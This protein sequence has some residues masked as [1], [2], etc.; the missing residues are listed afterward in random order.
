MLISA[1]I[2]IVTAKSEDRSNT[3]N[4][5]S[6]DRDKHTFEAWKTLEKHLKEID[7]KTHFTTGFLP[8]IGLK[9]IQETDELQD[10]RDMI[11]A[12]RRLYLHVISQENKACI[13][14]DECMIK[15]DAS[16]CHDGI[17]AL[18]EALPDFWK[19]RTLTDQALQI[20]PAT[21]EYGGQAYLRSDCIFY[22]QT[23]S[24][25]GSL[26]SETFAT[27]SEFRWALGF[28]SK[29]ALAAQLFKP[30]TLFKIDYLEGRISGPAA[31]SAAHYF[32]KESPDSN[33]V[34]LREAAFI[35]G[36]RNG[37]VPLGTDANG[38][39][40]LCEQGQLQYLLTGVLQGRLP[41]VWIDDTTE[42]GLANV[43]PTVAV[44]LN[45]CCMKANSLGKFDD[46]TEFLAFVAA[47][48]QENPFLAD[49]KFPE[50]LQAFHGGIESTAKYMSDADAAIPII[51]PKDLSAKG[52]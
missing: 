36:I 25:S 47:Y 26:I 49:G 51:D 13:V 4:V 9:M 33:E 27:S 32:C 18:V 34:S 43:V 37:V 44:L 35:G 21:V 14:F 15:E 39:Y 2:I 46:K 10:I 7:L 22:I 29:S 50:L 30:I 40:R 52:G 28:S 5:H 11:K 38:L 23:E 6:Q 1:Y 45:E 8:D 41:G 20:T 12:G 42:A 16:V 3:I 31:I 19:P 48:S 24:Q 17:V